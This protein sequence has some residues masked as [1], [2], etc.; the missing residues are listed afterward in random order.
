MHEARAHE[1]I[2]VTTA[3]GCWSGNLWWL[4]ILRGG[5]ASK[6]SSAVG[7]FQSDVWAVICSLGRAD[8]K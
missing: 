2:S 6:V 1:G 8:V 7:K 5:L 4:E 3:G